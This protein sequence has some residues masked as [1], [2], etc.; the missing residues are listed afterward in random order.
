MYKYTDFSVDQALDQH[1]G[2]AHFFGLTGN[3]VAASGDEHKVVPMTFV[4]SDYQVKEL[5]E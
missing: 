5:L 1:S 2:V 4:V 3:T